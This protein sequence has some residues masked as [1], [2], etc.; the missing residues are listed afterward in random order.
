MA[1]DLKIQSLRNQLKDTGICC[2]DG[3]H[4]TSAYCTLYD[5]HGKTVDGVQLDNDCELYTISNLLKKC[6]FCGNVF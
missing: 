3:W 6:P 5:T 4:L 2:E 1:R